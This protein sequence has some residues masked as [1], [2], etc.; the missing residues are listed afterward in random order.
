[1]GACKRVCDILA[2]RS[3]G[4][5]RKAGVEVYPS[6]LPKSKKADELSNSATKHRAHTQKTNER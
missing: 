5:Q 1:M 3:F 6:T 2:A 4:K